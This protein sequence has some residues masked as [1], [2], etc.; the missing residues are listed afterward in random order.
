MES[1]LSPGDKDGDVE[2]EVIPNPLSPKI[3]GT[4]LIGR[5]KVPLVPVD[6]T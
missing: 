3:M 2:H 1:M 5:P 4:T 6:P